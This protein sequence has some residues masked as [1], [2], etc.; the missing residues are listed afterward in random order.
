M[1]FF[2][3]IFKK[4]PQKEL[5]RAVSLLARGDAERALK[6]ALRVAAADGPM[7]ARAGDLAARARDDLVQEMM[8]NATRSESAGAFGDAA[9]WLEAACEH[10]SGEDELDD[11]RLRIE[12]LRKRAEA[13]PEVEEVPIPPEV[14]DVEEIDEEQYFQAVVGTLRPD[15]AERYENAGEAFRKAF[16]KRE[17]NRLTDAAQ[18]LEDLRA[19][20]PDDPLIKLEAARCALM[21]DKPEEARELA[22][23]VWGHF[24]D[25]SLDLA[26][27]LSVPAVWAE[28][29]LRLEQPEE[30][31]R[32]LAPIA[33][34]D[35]GN[36][37]LTMLYAS[38]LELS[39][40]LEEAVEVLAPARK[41]FPGN[42]WFP[43]HLART[44][45]EL[46]DWEEAI[47]CL[48]A[49]IAPSCA[50]GSCNRPRKHTPSIRYLIALYLGHQMETERV[51]ELLSHLEEALNG[52][53]Q[54]E[55]LRM[56][57]AYHRQMGDETA[58]TEAE[59]AAE[60][61]PV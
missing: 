49:S 61:L 52:Q 38:S 14:E 50:G 30:V 1:S 32:R 17:Q 6:I 56:I 2:K 23:A 26:H 28:A 5:D 7:A 18:D 24:G 40:R 16:L 39:K 25:E 42:P 21:R 54:G 10:E 51:G 4:D 3:K 44:L 29:M 36:A 9:D 34:N 15:I 59:A 48:E 58:A 37:H 11:L 41:A 12:D 22:E 45:D 35:R 20:N 55:D 8:R 31:S 57:A 19:A 27:M 13:E 60:R 47:S 46:G 43:F 53:F 33:A